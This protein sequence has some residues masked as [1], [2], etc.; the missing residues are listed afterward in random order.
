MSAAPTW[1]ASI[2][3]ARPVACLAAPPGLA[4][5]GIALWAIMG[6]A[7]SVTVWPKCR[8]VALEG[9]FPGSENQMIAHNYGD[10]LVKPLSE[11][12]EWSRACSR[13]FGRRNATLNVWF[14]GQGDVTWPLKP[15]LYRGKFRPELEREMLRD[16]RAHAA[17]YV[18]WL[19]LA[20][21]HGIP[22]RILDW[23][24]NPL[25]GLYFTCCE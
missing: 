25:V 6:I 12:V 16:F 3:T 13:R 8:H 23:T 14:R 21:H 17:E 20:Q 1:S 5:P 11:Y 18:D 22:T 4:T 9:R 10:G 19:F 2:S 24:E 15:S 7:K